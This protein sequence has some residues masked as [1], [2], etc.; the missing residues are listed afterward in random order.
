MTHDGFRA[1]LMLVG[2]LGLVGAILL[3]IILYC[4]RHEPPVYGGEKAESPDEDVIH[5]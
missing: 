4:E 3:A 1:L 5:G 2:G